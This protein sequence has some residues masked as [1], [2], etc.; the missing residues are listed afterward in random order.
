M[1]GLRAVVFAAAMLATS[2]ARAVD[3]EDQI[4]VGEPG[5]YVVSRCSIVGHGRT[6]A[7]ARVAFRRAVRD[8][9]RGW[10][11]MARDCALLRLTD[12]VRVAPGQRPVFFIAGDRGSK[13]T[14]RREAVRLC[15]AQEAA[16]RKAQPDVGPG[17][18]E[19]DRVTAVYGPFSRKR[20]WDAMDDENQYI[21]LDDK[22]TWVDEE[23][24]EICFPAGTP[25]ATPDGDRPIE[26]VAAGSRVLSWS[27]DRGAPVA[28]RV[29]DVKRR[30]AHELLELTLADGRTLKVSANHPLFVPARASFVPAGELRAGDQLGV[31]TDGGLA[32]VAVK[33]I[34]TRVAD[35]DVFD[36]TIESTHAYFA[37]GVLA[38][39]Y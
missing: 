16:E 5:V 1:S 6:E 13:A 34:A 15:R 38:H 37:G 24:R 25:I 4:R 32:P 17:N 28:A 27:I 26:T 10:H 9:K 7:E 39:N 30:R 35:T 29:L 31:L 3:P 21:F 14:D 36:L 19:C 22:G 18:L 33:T 2:G 12:V 11:N 23:G 20:A 8:A